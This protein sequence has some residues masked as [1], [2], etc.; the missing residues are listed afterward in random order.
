MNTRTLIL[1]AVASAALAVPVSQAAAKNALKLSS[2][3]LGLAATRIGTDAGQHNAIKLQRKHHV[4]IS[5]PVLS[6]A[7]PTEPAVS[8]S[9]GGSQ[10]SSVDPSLIAQANPGTA[11]PTA[12]DQ[13]DGEPGVY[14]N[15]D[16]YPYPQD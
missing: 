14:P 15:V 10:A 9:A 6:P 4:R 3:H 12:P 1:T 8:S 7:T 2:A 16:P 11:V 13:G 5:T